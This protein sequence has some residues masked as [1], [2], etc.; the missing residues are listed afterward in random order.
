MVGDTFTGVTFLAADLAAVE[1]FLGRVE[2]PWART[3]PD[4]VAIDLDA[5]M[6]ASYAFTDRV[7]QG[8]RRAR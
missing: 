6:G 5:S 7:L 4:L 2:V 1:Q 8:D 3:A